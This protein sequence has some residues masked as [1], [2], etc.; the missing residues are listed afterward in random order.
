MSKSSNPTNSAIRGHGHT[1][2]TYRIIEGRDAVHPMF[3]ICC[4]LEKYNFITYLKT[5]NK[6]EAGMT[7]SK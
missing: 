4:E 3:V 6:I 5:E 7:Q 1:N 2:V